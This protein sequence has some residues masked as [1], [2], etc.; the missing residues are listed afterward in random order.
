MYRDSKTGEKMVG[1][2]KQ[3]IKRKEVAETI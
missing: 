3:I 1:V 2:N